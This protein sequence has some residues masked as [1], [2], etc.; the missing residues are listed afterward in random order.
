M[1]E[2]VGRKLRELEAYDEEV[3]KVEHNKALLA[4]GALTK[5]EFIAVVRAIIALR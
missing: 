3:D 1:K 5:E 4:S 2:F